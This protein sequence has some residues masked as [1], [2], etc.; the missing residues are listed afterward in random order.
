M[1]SIQR[2]S[3]KCTAADIALAHSADHRGKQRIELILPSAPDAPIPLP[4]Y[5]PAQAGRNVKRIPRQYDVKL[6]S[7]ANETVKRNLFAFKEMAE[8][9]EEDAA[10]G[11]E[12]EMDVEDADD[13]VGGAD[14]DDSDDDQAMGGRGNGKQQGGKRRPPQQSRYRK[15][16]PKSEYRRGAALSRSHFHEVMLTL[17]SRSTRSQSQQPLRARSQTKRPSNRS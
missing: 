11:T 16:R 7:D 8:E 9:E 17:L 15:K 3:L 5:D 6:S 12:G 14:E 4:E 10:E 13:S 2:L 1:P